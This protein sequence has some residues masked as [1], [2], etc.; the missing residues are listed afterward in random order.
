MQILKPE[1]AVAA[2]LG[3]YRILDAHNLAEKFKHPIR[4]NFDIGKALE[5][6]GKSGFS[7]FQTTRNRI[8]H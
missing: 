3:I 8:Y 2:A 7:L 1:Q 4:D 5:F 6:N